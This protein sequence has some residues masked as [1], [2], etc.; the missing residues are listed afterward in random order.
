LRRSNLR[1]VVTNSGNSLT[2]GTH[3]VAQTLKRRTLAVPPLRNA[4]TPDAS[5]GSRSTG[6]LFHFSVCSAMPACLVRHL[7]EQ[8]WGL[9]T[10]T[11]TGRPASMASTAL[12]ASVDLTVAGSAY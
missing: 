5:M 6:V 12:R 11:G 2:H 8:P 9:V 4:A 1:D 7:V 10:G 3:Q